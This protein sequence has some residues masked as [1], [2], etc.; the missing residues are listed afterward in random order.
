MILEVKV[1][2]GAASTEVVGWEGERLRVRLAAPPEK[3]KANAALLQFL[4]KQLKISRS[5]LELISGETGRIKRIRIE[6]V[7]LNE[8]RSRL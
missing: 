2:P 6:G 8:V 7:D 4:A 3:G 5:S 1:T